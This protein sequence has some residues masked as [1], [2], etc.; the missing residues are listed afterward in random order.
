M[1]FGDMR[2]FKLLNKSSLTFITPC[3]TLHHAVPCMP[4]VSAASSTL[5]RPRLS[6]ALRQELKA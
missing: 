2:L 3:T 4:T 5:K 6:H 1:Q